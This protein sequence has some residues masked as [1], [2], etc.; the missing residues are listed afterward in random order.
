MYTCSLL[1]AVH[2]NFP[3]QLI[4]QLQNDLQHL[5]KK[6]CSPHDIHVAVQLLTWR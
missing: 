2:Y 3:T 6:A 1:L 5:I 4:G